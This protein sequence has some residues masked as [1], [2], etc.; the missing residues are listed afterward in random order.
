MAFIGTPLDTR[1][2]FQS[3][4]GKRFSGDGSTTGFTLDV[5]PGSVL[6][7]EVFVGNVR[8]DPN[9]AYTLSGTTL[10]FTGAPPSGTN[11]IYVVHQAKSV[12]TIDVPALGVSTAS[13]QADAITEAKIADDAVESEHL[14]NNIISGQT[15]LGA[16]PADTD[17]FLVSDAG[18]IKRVDYSYIKGELNTPYFEVKLSGNVDISDAANTKIAFNTERFDSANDFDSSSNYR[19][20]PQTAGKYIYTLVVYGLSSNA[21]NSN[22]RGIVADIK[23]NGSRVQVNE[24]DF[25]A[26]DARQAECVSTVTIDMNGSSDYVEF[27]A[28]VNTVDG[29]DGRLSEYTMARGWRLTT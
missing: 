26:N 20:T 23:K 22:L 5:A 1:N 27:F 24:F 14:N 3:L 9:S 17:E 6:D 13:I 28:E 8:Q 16:T 11:N 15:A 4:V 10:T 21:A 12:G 2:T 18:T 7:I 29:A 19:H 25:N